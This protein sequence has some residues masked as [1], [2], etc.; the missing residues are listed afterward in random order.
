MTLPVS[1]GA[2][3]KYVWT[4][5]IEEDFTFPSRFGDVVQAY[6]RDG[7]YIHLPR[8]SHPWADNPK[9]Q[10]DF[11][12]G[13]AL[14]CESKFVA[15]NADQARVV[16]EAEREIFRG[17][18]V[19]Q[20]PTG[21]GKTYIGSEIICRVNQAA[22]VITTKDD[23][24]DQWVTALQLVLGLEE[25][26][27]GVWRGDQVP[28]PKC[29]VAVG[30]VQS[31][32][33]GPERYSQELYD[34]WGFILCDEVHRMGADKFSDA[35]WWLRG[36]HRLG[37][38]ATPYR[39]D[40]KDRVFKEHIGEVLVTA[41]QDV[42]VPK[43]LSTTSDWQVPPNI[44]V[45]PARMTSLAKSF[46]ASTN[47]N[48]KIAAFVKGAYD[49]KRITIVFADTIGHLEAIEEQLI[50]IGLTHRDLGWYVGLTSNKYSGGKQ[51][52][53]EQRELVKIAPVILATYKMASEATDIPWLDT[54]VLGS[55][56]S[57]VVQIVGRIRREYEG[58]Q[59]PLVMDLVDRASGILINFSKSREKWYAS[60]GA[61]VVYY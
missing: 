31:I 35:M 53:K 56:R 11:V 27:V 32:S 39:K 2:S 51:A 52:R 13:A 60:I 50:A 17:D 28:N 44:T 26:E 45:E 54:C 41:K 40:G 5:K 59:Q 6:R 24:I 61:E 58:K 18:F 34:R 25:H 49:R 29:K 30:L 38:S 12:V 7:E 16:Q 20:A 36:K 22:L 57:D 47:R 10:T 15:R 43:I 42:L 21:Y 19:L 46:A 37:L 9:V 23:I 33:K 55:P 1:L 4:S 14:N 3:A 8:N 48:I